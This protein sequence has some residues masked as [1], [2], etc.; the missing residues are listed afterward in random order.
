MRWLLAVGALTLTSCRGIVAWGTVY[1]SVSPDGALELVVQEKGCFAD[2]ALRVGLKR[3]WH[4]EQIA[5]KSD[6]VV[7]FAHAEWSG[8]TVATFVDGGY[9]GDIRVAYDMKARRLVDF[10]S[11][12]PWLRDSIIKAYG[13]THIELQQNR[14]DIFA[15][16]TYPGD[17]SPR[18]SMEEF[19]K[20]FPGL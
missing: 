6:C 9:C 7:N 8:T 3:G 11:A 4:T 19:H 12:E 2:C 1:N 5:W 10:T 20:R 16:A 13:V 15:W 14:G 18:R 17:G